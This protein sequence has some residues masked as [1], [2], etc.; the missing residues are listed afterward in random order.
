MSEDFRNLR[1]TV[2]DIGARIGKLDA[3]VTDL[4]NMVN[5]V[6]AP[7][8]APP[9]SPG[10]TTG[11]PP[12]GATSNMPPATSGPVT[13]PAGLRAES[14]YS[15]AYRDYVGGQYDL[16]MSEFT[17]YIKYFNETEWAPNSQFYIGNIY[18]KK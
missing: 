5:V 10:G 6:K 2:N 9:S 18:Y 11:T 17:D 3:K 7:Q 12:N 15:N 13:P 16:A 14:L 8:V 4:Q 1:E